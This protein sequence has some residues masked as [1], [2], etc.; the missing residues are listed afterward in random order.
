MRAISENAEA[1]L[2]LAKGTYCLLDGFPLTFITIMPLSSA[3]EEPP[4]P[5]GTHLVSRIFK[6]GPDGSTF[7][8]AIQLVFNCKSIKIPEG[9]GEED[10][11]IATW[12]EENLQWIRLES[13]LIPENGQIVTEI[14][15][16]SMYAVMVSPQPAHISVTELTAV[17][18]EISEGESTTITASL[19]NDGELA[20]TYEAELTV[21]GE[22]V[23]TKA[24]EIGGQDNASVTFDLTG[25]A[26]GTY[27]ISV[28]EA[29]VTLT[30]L[31]AKEPTP[32]FFIPGSLEIIPAEVDTDE[33][34]RISITVENTGESE[35]TYPV[36]CKI[37][38]EIKE[39]KEV[40][41][42]GLSSDTVVF[43]MAFE[44]AGKKL[45]D[46]NDQLGGV[47]VRGAVPPTEQ[48]PL[49]ADDDEPS[50]PDGDVAE[51]T[52][53][54]ITGDSDATTTTSSWP[55]VVGVVGGC[56]VLAII[57]TLYVIRRKRHGTPENP[58]DSV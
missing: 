35:G 19:I 43:T 42:Q 16:F 54:G 28:G 49:P 26:S 7:D 36:I 44:E 20:G 38:G 17:P 47:I 14:S 57:T 33:E 32:A 55:I 40:F 11:Y 58:P 13:Q 51:I 4:I 41:L 12:D 1:F 50:T 46:V 15:G 34:V 53:P 18:D 24:V 3:D 10:M 23:E 39:E 45:I 52:E 21:N 48:T 5:E 8:P 27:Q 9:F 37:N 29:A 22:V 30:V 25:L 31:P 56:L 6:L 2:I